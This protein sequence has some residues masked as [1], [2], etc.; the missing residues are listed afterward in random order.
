MKFAS[1]KF[2]LPPTH[3]YSHDIKEY[4]I[5]CLCNTV[6]KKKIVALTF[7]RMKSKFR[8]WEVNTVTCSGCELLIDGDWIM[9]F[10]A[11]YSHTSG[12]QAIQRNRWSTH[13]YSSPL[14]AHWVSQSSLVVFWQRIYNSHCSFK[15]H[16]KFSFHSLIPFL[17]LFCTCQHRRLDSVQFLCDQAHIPA[18][19][20][21]ETRL[22][23]G[24]L[25]WSLLY[26]HF[27]RTTQKTQPL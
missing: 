20:R 18:G 9:G 7:E 23:Y 8:R 4:N 3:R 5:G 19:W 25:N 14:H 24:S 27:A 11:P 17:L 2:V 6:G 16:M 12:Q 15:S 1:N 22:D 13:S 21:L 26:Y 10:T